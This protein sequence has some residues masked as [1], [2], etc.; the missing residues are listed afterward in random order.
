MKCKFD[1][2]NI[3]NGSSLPR[4]RLETEWDAIAA[5]LC[6]FRRILGV[7]ITRKPSTLPGHT[8]SGFRHPGGADSLNALLRRD[9]GVYLVNELTMPPKTQRAEA[10]ARRVLVRKPH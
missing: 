6:C 5:G 8:N 2:S 9:Q 7:R 10:P 3:G 1:Q 4:I